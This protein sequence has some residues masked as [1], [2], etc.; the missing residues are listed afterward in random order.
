MLFAWTE[1]KAGRA[2]SGRARSLRNA[3]C[4]N[5]PRAV[6]ESPIP[7]PAPSRLCSR[8]PQRAPNFESGRVAAAA[9]RLAVGQWVSFTKKLRLR[10]GKL[11]PPPSKNT[12]PPSAAPR[13]STSRSPLGVRIHH[14]RRAHPLSRNRTSRTWSRAV[15]SPRART[16]P[17]RGRPSPPRPARRL[18]SRDS[19]TVG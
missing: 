7:A 9:A 2:R 3:Q 4:S 13:R 14:R 19:T 17:T 11:T 16:R 8:L 6:L 15:P 18:R 1:K 10:L 5:P 12:A